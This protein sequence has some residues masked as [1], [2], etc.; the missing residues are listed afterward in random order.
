MAISINPSNTQRRELSFLTPRGQEA[1]LAEVSVPLYVVQTSVGGQWKL[2]I[3][4]EG[5]DRRKSRRTC[6]SEPVSKSSYS[7]INEGARNRLCWGFRG[8]K[9]K[10]DTTDDLCSSA[11]HP[12]P[13]TESPWWAKN[14]VPNSVLLK[15]LKINKY[16]CQTA[17][18]CQ[19]SR[20]II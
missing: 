18:P 2:S 11:T 13:E 16:M 17:L 1:T 7:G 3:L 9:R 15:L 12:R 14:T 10:A 5:D 8:C 4:K 19:L 6:A 20:I